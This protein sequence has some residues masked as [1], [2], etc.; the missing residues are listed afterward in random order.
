LG[1]LPAAGCLCTNPHTTSRSPAIPANRSET[2]R[3]D[4]IVH[5]AVL[6]FALLLIFRAVRSLWMISQAKRA[7]RADL[8][9]KSLTPLKLQRLHVWRNYG[10]TSVA[11]WVLS[12]DYEVICKDEDDQEAKLWYTIDFVP[13]V[14]R[15]RALQVHK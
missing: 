13:L 3:I 8:A 10:S 6:I 15:I 9:A 7:I 1:L 2:E 11:F 14:G 4:V 5:L 12:L